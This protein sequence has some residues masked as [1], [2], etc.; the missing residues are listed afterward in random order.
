[1]RGDGDLAGHCEKEIR[2]ILPV[3]QILAKSTSNRSNRD[4]H[5]ERRDRRKLRHDRRDNRGNRGNGH[6]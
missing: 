6:R 1:L 5:Q 2:V 4:Q 3:P